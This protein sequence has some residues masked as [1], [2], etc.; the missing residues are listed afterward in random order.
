MNIL[1]VEDDAQLGPLMGELLRHYDRMAGRNAIAGIRVALDFN[2]AVE[3]LPEADVVLCDGEFPIS[4]ATTGPAENWSLVAYRAEA[5]Q[6]PV[7]VYS[8]SEVVVHKASSCGL[9]ALAKPA[10]ASEVYDALMFAYE[11]RRAMAA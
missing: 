4:D 10:P 9:L 3:C 8:G 11:K 2:S 5:R 6:T 7:V 1:I